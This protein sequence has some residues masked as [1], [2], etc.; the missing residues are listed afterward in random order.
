MLLKEALSDKALEGTSKVL[1]LG[2]YILETLG[3]VGLPA[4][5]VAAALLSLRGKPSEDVVGKKKKRKRRRKS[6]TQATELVSVEG[7]GDGRLSAKSGGRGASARQQKNDL[8]HRALRFVIEA[9]SSSPQQV[10]SRILFYLADAL[11][12]TLDRPSQ[13]DLERAVGAFVE[14]AQV[15][16]GSRVR[17]ERIPPPLGR[18]V[19]GVVLSYQER[20]D[21]I[22]PAHT[23]NKIR[24]GMHFD[25]P[26]RP[27]DAT[28]QLLP[29]P[30]ARRVADYAGGARQL[31]LLQ[32]QQQQQQLLCLAN[33]AGGGGSSAL[34]L[35]PTQQQLLQLRLL[36]QEEDLESDRRYQQDLEEQDLMGRMMARSRGESHVVVP[37]T[38][39]SFPPTPESRTQLLGDYSEFTEN[40]LYRARDEL[41]GEQEDNDRPRMAIFNPDDA[42]PKVLLSCGG[43]CAALEQRAPQQRIY[44]SVRAALSLQYGRTT[45]FEICPVSRAAPDEAE[46]PLHLCV[47]LSTKGMPLRNTVAGCSPTTVGLDSSGVMLL[48]GRRTRTTGFT[49]GQVVGVCVRAW[50]SHMQVAFFVDGEPVLCDAADLGIEPPQ[51]QDHQPPSDARVSEFTIR[52]DAGAQPFFPTVSI[53]SNKVKV[54]GHFSAADMNHP[55]ADLAFWARIATFS[56][57]EPLF[58][59][60]GTRL[61]VKQVTPPSAISS[62]RSPLLLTA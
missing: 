53:K 14:E 59:L 8:F 17:L 35:L 44:T 9:R 1:E 37:C 3:S 47:G 11:G 10:I 19:T 2:V 40:V 13:R 5:Q 57:G 31:L 22:L 23:L 28:V 20:E 25:I 18:A 16:R 51:E 30:S 62:P 27:F 48:S 43:H 45:Y 38:P 39:S 56:P 54:F 21:L 26:I 52:N 60:D 15:Q 50:V 24:R 34:V 29:A 7:R 41:R 61:L 33:E 58:A 36:S 49:Y 12:E 4:E 55:E 6:S 42:H 32:Q 46:Q